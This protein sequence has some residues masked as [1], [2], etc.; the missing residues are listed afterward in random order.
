MKGLDRGKQI[1][2]KQKARAGLLALPYRRRN[3]TQATL[4][5]DEHILSRENREKNPGRPCANPRN[6]ILGK[7]GRQ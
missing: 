4:Y 5:V 2:Q 7:E 1:P 3:I 6:P